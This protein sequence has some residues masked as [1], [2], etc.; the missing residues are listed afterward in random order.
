MCSQMSFALNGQT[1]L[2]CPSGRGISWY[3]IPR[4]L[5][6]ATIDQAFGLNLPSAR[7]ISAPC[8]QFIRHLDR[9]AFAERIHHEQ[10]GADR[11][12]DADDNS[13]TGAIAGDCAGGARQFR[14]V[15]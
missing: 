14:I 12:E 13:H 7:G 15:I 5:P 6:S 1:N 8:R 9:D 4:A 3:K 10:D 11:E 2:E